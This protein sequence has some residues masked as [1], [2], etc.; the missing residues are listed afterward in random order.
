MCIWIIWLW[1]AC[2]KLLCMQ[3]SAY[4]KQK[5]AHCCN[6]VSFWLF[7]HVDYPGCNNLMHSLIQELQVRG[8]IYGN[9]QQTAP[10][11][12]HWRLWESW[13]DQERGTEHHSHWNGSTVTMFAHVAPPPFWPQRQGSSYPSVLPPLRIC[14]TS[15][16]ETNNITSNVEL[17][18]VSP[19]E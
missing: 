1:D 6:V 4:D 10:W 18:S 11:W 14:K 9:Q 2:I 16:F 17:I 7:L 5:Q 3:W 19:C 8:G 12:H 15:V 13:E